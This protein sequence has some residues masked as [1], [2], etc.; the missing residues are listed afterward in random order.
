MLLQRPP[1]LRRL[2]GPPAEREHRRPLV[3]QGGNR[4]LGFEHP[5]PG[6][7]PLLEQLRDR[8]P[9]RPRQLVVEIDQA[10]AQPVCHLQA[11]RRLARAHE[12]DERDVPV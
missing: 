7:A 8:P 2:D 1:D 5:K 3:V 4:G 9:G 12:P 6:L 11:E 10:P